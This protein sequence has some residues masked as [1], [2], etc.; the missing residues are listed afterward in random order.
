M[1]GGLFEL[2]GDDY[3]ENPWKTSAVLHERYI[4]DLAFGLYIDGP[5]EVVP[6]VHRSIPVPFLYVAK[7]RD[8]YSTELGQMAKIVVARQEDH[9]LFVT[10]ALP[11]RDK[12]VPLPKV[13]KDSDDP[14]SEK[15]V[16]DLESQLRLLAQPGT[17]RVVVLLKDRASNRIELKV[18]PP[19]AEHADPE[20]KTFLDSFRK[21]RP[22]LP[23]GAPSPELVWTE[24]ASGPAPPA[25]A[26][27]VPGKDGIAMKVERVVLNTAGAEAILKCSFR[28]GVLKSELVPP[29]LPR[30]TDPQA[31]HELVVSD[32]YG[33]PRPTAILPITIVVLGSV[34]PSHVVISLQVPVFQPFDTTAP[35]RSATGRFAID[36]LAN[37][38]LGITPQTFAIYAFGG[39][40]MSGPVLM[41]TVTEDML[42]KPGE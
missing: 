7:M 1:S 29:P 2:S 37:P 27:P 10:N 25:D 38:N 5:P 15:H 40:E 11:P 22:T 24:T 41:A 18:A 30:A 16:I 39:G 3:W 33:T 35:E 20:V 42:P 9:A 17:Y 4:L 28:L 6:G 34:T 31:P 23:P 32:P 12:E 36:L 21:P 26:P 13:G 8:A 19:R 14:T